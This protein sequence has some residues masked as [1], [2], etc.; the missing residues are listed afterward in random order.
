MLVS[1][2][3]V[4]IKI[5]LLRVP[6]R[7]SYDV[8][9]EHSRDLKQWGRQRQITTVNTITERWNKLGL[10]PCTQL[11]LKLEHEKRFFGVLGTARKL[12]QKSCQYLLSFME[13]HFKLK[14]KIVLCSPQKEIKS[15]PEMLVLWAVS[16]AFLSSL[17]K[18]SVR[19][20]QSGLWRIVLQWHQQTQPD[21]KC[22]CCS[23]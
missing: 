13:K 2:T 5:L 15:K 22:A 20:P 10:T 14:I 21:L 23:Y 11:S 3:K 19:F 4:I 18:V 9:W 17:L 16:F 12:K 1:Q 7:G 6:Q 8:K